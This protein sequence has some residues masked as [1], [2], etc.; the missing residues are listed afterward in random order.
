MNSDIGRFTLKMRVFVVFF[1]C[2]AVFSLQDYTL[3]KLILNKPKRIQ[4]ITATPKSDSANQETSKLIV[5][6]A[7]LV[8]CGDTCA[9][10]T[11]FEI[12]KDNTFECHDERIKLQFSIG[13]IP[14]VVG[15]Y[16]NYQ[17]ILFNEQKQSATCPLI[18][19]YIDLEFFCSFI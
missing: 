3:S 16:E 17:P 4:K 9:K 14:D 1:I 15:F 2:N 8:A 13:N 6:N 11:E 7:T 19:R 12:H 18:K 5:K 10:V